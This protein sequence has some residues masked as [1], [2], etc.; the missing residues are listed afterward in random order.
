MVTQPTE[1]LSAEHTLGT[2]WQLI[3]IT[4]GVIAL[5]GILAIAF[6]FVTGLSVA[7]VLG[8]VLVVSGIVHGAAGI[9][10]RRWTGAVWQLAV[11]AVTVIAGLLMLANPVLGLVTLT[12]LAIAY[13]LVDG[14]TELAA[15]RRVE[16]TDR[17]YIVASGI[18][19]LVLAGLLWAGFPASAAWAVGVIVGVSLLSTGASM[20]VISMSGRRATKVDTGMA[21]SRKA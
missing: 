4:G 8:A 13:L 2:D 1:E 5:L 11:G 19:S 15:S 3:A 14:I 9:T 12:V 10:H 20:F 16:G 21:G 17:R 6:P 7:Y 18:L